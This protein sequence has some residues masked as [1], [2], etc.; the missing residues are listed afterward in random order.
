LNPRYRSRYTR[1][2]VVHLR[3]LG[4]LSRSAW[5]RPA[6]ANVITAAVRRLFPLLV[7]R[8]RCPRTPIRLLEGSGPL[9]RLRPIQS[10]GERGIRTPGTV[11]GT[12]DFESGAFDQLGQLSAGGFNRSSLRCQAPSRTQGPF[13]S[14]RRA[15]KKARK[16]SLA[17][18][19]RTPRSTGKRWFRRGS[20]ER[21]MR[22]P[23]APALGS[24][25]A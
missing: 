4:H 23:T 13:T 18:S 15:R 22:E 20:A 8:G 12:P 16:S 19:A 17:S 25:A 5:G 7:P 24:L 9:L 6:P 21:S 11:T 2:P 14:P 1:F 3:P 10:G